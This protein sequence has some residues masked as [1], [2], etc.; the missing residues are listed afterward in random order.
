MKPVNSENFPS[1]RDIMVG[2][3]RDVIRYKDGRVVETPWNKNL[4]VDDIIKAIACA[5]KGD[6]GIKYWAVGKGLDAWDDVN[7]PAPAVGDTQLVDE[8]GR[9]AIS[10]GSFQY[11]DGA[12]APSVPITNRILITVVFDYVDCNG[13]WREFAIVGG[14]TAA[15]GENTGILLNHKTHGLIVK[16]NSMEIERQIRFTFNN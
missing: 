8:I 13:N 5:L 3:F 2:E 11:V 4:I 15:E 9:K 12:G 10:A 7:P 16:T 1:V 14:S 6:A